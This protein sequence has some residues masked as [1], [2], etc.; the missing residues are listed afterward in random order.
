MLS[1][2]QIAGQ[3]LTWEQPKRS[4]RHFELRVGDAALA[5]LRWEKAFRSQAIAE[6][7]DGAS[8]SFERKGWGTSVLVSGGE[9]PGVLFQRSGWGGKGRLTLPDG[10]S[11]LWTRPRFWGTTWAWVSESGETLISLKQQPGFFKMGG[12]VE[13]APGAVLLPETPLLVLLGWYLMVI[14]AD[15][16]ASSAAVTA[17]VVS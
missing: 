13:V 5:T 9:A 16:A 10:R 15:D 6:T 14:A 7:A 2:Q 11:W 17:V 1:F 4:A 3:T 12:Q 8:W